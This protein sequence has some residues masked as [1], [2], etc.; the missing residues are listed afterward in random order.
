MRSH[1]KAVKTPYLVR[2]GADDEQRAPSEP[3]VLWVQ[4]SYGVA[5]PLGR[6][7]C[8]VHVRAHDL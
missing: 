6:Q 7:V 4:H 2:P 5:Q 8:C 1:L 3:R